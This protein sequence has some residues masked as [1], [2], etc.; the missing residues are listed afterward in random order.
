MNNLLC[1]DQEKRCSAKQAL[2]HRWFS[3]SLISLSNLNN[4]E[5]S[6]IRP[7][8]CITTKN[9]NII[10][11]NEETKADTER[12]YEYNKT[13]RKYS[14]PQKNTNVFLSECKKSPRKKRYFGSK[15]EMKA[16]EF[17]GV[18]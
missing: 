9:E 3:S 2:S 16:I 17:D 13:S 5:T 6:Q 4:K 10:L 8:F 12:L 1:L 7:E 14:P 11:H 15:N 18:K